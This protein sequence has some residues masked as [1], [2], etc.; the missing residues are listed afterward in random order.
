MDLLLWR[1]ADA[2]EGFPDLDRPLTRKG[3]K[4][5]RRVAQWLDGHLPESTRILVSPALRA[6]QTAQPLLEIGG[7]KARTVARLAPGAS[8][9]DIL[10]AAEWPRA[11]NPVLIVSHQPTLG[12]VAS[13][14]LGGV[15]QPW[16]I[17]KG[18]LWWLASQDEEEGV[19]ASLQAVVHSSLLQV[20]AD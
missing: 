19:Q 8:V 9:I 11:R 6:Q 18:A 16:A 20:A 14:L 12:M 7:R 2:A 4:Q 5:A 1:H 17:R 13:F 15:E 3:E 10:A